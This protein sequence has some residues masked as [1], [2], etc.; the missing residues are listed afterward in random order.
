MYFHIGT[1]IGG[2]EMSTTCPVI[3]IIG[4]IIMIMLAHDSGMAQ[5]YH[6]HDVALKQTYT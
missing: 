2:S 4:I 3:V 5:A 1:A 6:G